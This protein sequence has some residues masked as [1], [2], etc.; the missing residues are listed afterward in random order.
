MRLRLLQ[1]T[2]LSYH[3][4]LG[5]NYEYLWS[6]LAQLSSPNVYFSIDVG[7]K[8]TAMVIILGKGAH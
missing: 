2:Y 5:P 8:V 1:S 4:D 3:E 6:S 7:L